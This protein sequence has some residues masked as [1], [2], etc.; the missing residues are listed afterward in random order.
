M[1]TLKER[2]N[3]ERDFLKDLDMIWHR[4]LKSAEEKAEFLTKHPRYMELIASKEINYYL[5]SQQIF[6]IL[7]TI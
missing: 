6:L 5:T 7:F 3:N 1:I 2:Q 4:Q